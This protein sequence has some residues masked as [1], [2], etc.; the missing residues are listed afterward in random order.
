MYSSI[1]VC[2]IVIRCM[3]IDVIYTQT[4]WQYMLQSPCMV[5]ALRLYILLQP[6]FSNAHYATPPL[7]NT[8][9][10]DSKQAPFSMFV[11]IGVTTS[12]NQT[13]RVGD[14]KTKCSIK[15]KLTAIKNN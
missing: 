4:E 11:G 13:A 1:C 7:P 9:H 2:G 10:M 3:I 14:R 8:D 15:A 12:D 6:L 5:P